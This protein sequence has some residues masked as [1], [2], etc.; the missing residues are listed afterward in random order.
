MLLRSGDPSFFHSSMWAGVLAATYGYKPIYLTSFDG[1]RFAFLMPLME[2]RSPLTGRRG[3]SLPFTDR[4]V[5][6]TTEAGLLRSGI[7]WAIDHGR[8]SGWRYVEWRDGAYF[9]ENVPESESFYTHDLGL[10]M[11]EAGR[12]ATLK[13]STRR[14]ITRAMESGVTVEIDRSLDAVKAF[15]R[16]NCIT[17]KRHGLPPQPY[18]FF[19]NIQTHILAK[20]NGFVI[21]ARHGG[22]IIAAAVFFHFGASAIY[23]YGASDM[24]YSKWRPNNLVMWEAIRWYESRNYETLNMGRTE[25]DNSGL[26]RYKLGWGTRESVI[27]YFRYH[28]R[29]RAFV[30]SPAVVGI[31]RKR[32]LSRT[33]LHVLRL[34]GRILNKHF[35]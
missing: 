19:R 4:C 22:E 3:I 35:G 31:G 29:K 13:D 23:K 18:A 24:A 7:D 16:L 30:R 11:N 27:K 28:L 10:G 17:R 25:P 1:D 6:F 8:R 32:I 26:R 20:D 15:H 33:P 12:F 5:P 34:I 9:D 2:V 14:N 21:S